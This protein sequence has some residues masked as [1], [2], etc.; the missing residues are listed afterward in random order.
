M[1]I[2]D[3]KLEALLRSS[4]AVLTDA[5][6]SAVV[7]ATLPRA[8]IGS[9]HARRWTLGVSAVV[10][11]ALTAAFAAPVENLFGSYAWGGTGLS[12]VVTM[13]FVALVTVPTVRA[14]YSN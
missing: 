9:T 10:G 8:R 4:E 1:D 12:A 13:L 3:A 2:S 6:F 5:G 7:M 14:L 11:G